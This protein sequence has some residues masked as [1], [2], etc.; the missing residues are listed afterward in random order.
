MCMY[1]TGSGSPKYFPSPGTPLSFLGAFMYRGTRTDRNGML[2][3]GATFRRVLIRER[4]RQRNHTARQY[5]PRSTQGTTSWHRDPI[6]CST[7]YCLV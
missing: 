5:L 6:V 2:A 7:I 4:Y 1:M 3:P